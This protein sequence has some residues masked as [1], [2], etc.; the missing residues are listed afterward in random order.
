MSLIFYC[1]TNKEI[2][3]RS[4]NVQRVLYP[5]HTS[6]YLPNVTPKF[7]KSSQSLCNFPISVSYSRAS[8]TFTDVSFGIW[9]KS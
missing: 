7:F 9:R 2:N 5:L 1:F 4:S 3:A 6:F 8:S